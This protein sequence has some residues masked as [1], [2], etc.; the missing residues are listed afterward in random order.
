LSGKLDFLAGA[1]VL[2]MPRKVIPIIAD[3]KDAKRITILA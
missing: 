2:M 3:S 1:M